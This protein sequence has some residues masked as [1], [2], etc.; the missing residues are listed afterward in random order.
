[1]P[2]WYYRHL[3]VGDSGRDVEAIQ[4]RLGQPVDG[5]YSL[6]TAAAVRGLQRRRGLDPTGEVDL[7]TAESIGESAS[8]HL[9][10]RWYSRELHRGMH[11]VDVAMVRQRLG[12]DGG[13]R[14]DV[15]L[16]AAVRRHQSALGIIPT[17]I[18]NE[19]L[20]LLLGE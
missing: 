18:V 9:S 2:R 11:G 15:D 5:K 14:F 1:M 12:L 13:D 6:D 16:V 17:G 20:A 4:R 19:S 3:S 7:D 10:P 8:A